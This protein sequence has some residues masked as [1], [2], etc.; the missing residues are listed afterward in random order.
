MCIRPLEEDLVTI[1]HELGHNFYQRAYVNLPTLFASGANDGFHEA[2]GDA[3][4]LSITPAYLKQL[5]LIDR[6][7]RDDRGAVDFQMKKALEKIAFLPWGKLVDQWR[8]DVFAGK[9]PPDRYDEAWWELRTRYQ[10]VSRP[11][12]GTAGDFDPGA[13][14]HVP[15]NVPY[16][17]YFL[18][19]IYQFQF[20][21]ALCDASGWKGPLHQCSFHGSKEAG[22]KLQAMLEMGA[23]RPWP[24][25]YVILTGT[26]KPD[27]TPMLEYFAP[28]RAFLEKENAGRQCAW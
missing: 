17:R 2:I 26:R 19:A 24:E 7:P 13:K 3:I 21:K 25:A 20:Y 11:A 10:G 23:S 18:A 1:H 9:V 5:G 27:A 28:L 16:A 12:P 14:Y 15:A 6:L 22:K 8:W 4:A